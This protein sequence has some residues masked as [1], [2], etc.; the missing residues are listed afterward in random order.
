M[1]LTLTSN[2]HVKIYS[3]P[4]DTLACDLSLIGTVSCDIDYYNEISSYNGTVTNQSKGKITVT[5]ECDH[6]PI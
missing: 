5:T 2:K 4:G 1:S 6:I 3:H